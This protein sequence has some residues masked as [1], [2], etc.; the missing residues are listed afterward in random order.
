MDIKWEE[1]EGTT[2]D[3]ER[4]K[5]QKQVTSSQDTLAAL[6]ANIKKQGTSILARE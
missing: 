1:K 5:S 6:E 2:I 4:N 3:T